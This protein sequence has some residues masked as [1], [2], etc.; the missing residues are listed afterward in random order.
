MDAD[1]IEAEE[2]SGGVR[3][4]GNEVA[5]LPRIGDAGVAEV[6]RGQRRE[7][8]EAGFGKRRT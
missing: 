8:C 1:E 2:L 3:V 4:A 7:R 5:Q 6:T